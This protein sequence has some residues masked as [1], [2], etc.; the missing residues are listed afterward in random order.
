MV[1]RGGEASAEADPTVVGGG[2]NEIF[3]GGDAA[4]G[5]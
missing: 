5:G 2:T 3:Y 1:R 4:G